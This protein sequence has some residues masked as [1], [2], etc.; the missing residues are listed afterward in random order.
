MQRKLFL[1][2]FVAAFVPVLVFASGKISGKVTDAGTGE[3]LVGANVVV[4]GTQMGAATNVSGEYVILNVPTGTYTIRSTYVGY[5][6]ITITNLMVNNDLT[7]EAN[8]QLP[9]EGVTVG[10]VEI[11]A[12]RPLVNKNATNAVRIIDADFFT[13]VP[14]RGINAAIQT[15]P[16]VVY[17]GGNIYIRGGRADEVGYQLEGVG[18]NDIVNGGRA[19]NITAEAVEQIQVQAGGF[20]AEY[21]GANAGLVQ[22]QLRTG[23]PDKWKAS[24]LGETDRYMGLNKPSKLGGYSYGYGDLTATAGGPIVSNKFRFFGSLQGTYYGDQSVRNQAGGTRAPYDFSGANAIVAD[25]AITFGHSS[26]LPDTLNLVLPGGNA[27]GGYERTLIGS[28]TL[29]IDLS[30][31]QVRLAGSYAYDRNK[32]QTTLANLLN[33]G[34]LGLNT[35]RD[36]FGNVK[37]SHVISPTMF[38]EANFDYYNQTFQTE[39]PDFGSNV[40]AYGDSAANAALGYHLLANSLNY[41]A[42]SLWGGAFGVNQPGTQIAGFEKRSQTSIGGRV[43]F[44]MQLKQHEVKVG[45]SY[46]R[47]TIRE[48]NPSSELSWYRLQKEATSADQLELELM[49]IGGTGSNTYGYDVFG[50]QINGDVIK[51]GAFYYMGPRHPG[52]GAAYIQDKIELSDIILN[53]GLR[54]DYINPDS[55]DVK[56]PS[57]LTFTGQDLIVSDNIIATGKTNQISPRIGLSFPVTDRTVFHAQFGKFIQQTKLSDSYLGASSMAGIIKGGF[58]VTGTWGWGLKPTRTTQY[59][60]GFSQQVSDFASFDINAFFKDIQDQIDWANIAPAPGTGGQNYAALVNRDFSTSQGVEFK[61]TMRRTNRISASLGYTFSSVTTTGSNTASAAGLWSAGSVVALPHYTFPADWN[62]THRG[63]VLFDYRFA[64]NDGGPVLEQLGLDVLLTFNSGHNFT[65]LI[66]QQRI[67]GNAQPTDPRF[68]IPVEPIGS[69]TS[70]WFF[71]LDARLD[72]TFSVG[73]LDLNVYVYV[74]NLLGTDNPVGAFFRTGDPSDDGWFSTAGGRADAVSNGQ[75]YVDFY[76]AVAL[77][78]NS[79]NYGP[80]RQIRFGLKL[81]Y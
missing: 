16:G 15:A 20:T 3:P 24:L 13:N 58:F 31:V 38:Y 42:Y 63:T 30:P 8:F 34:R 18:V 23:S 22:T 68:R 6:T 50:N 81:D 19:V 67:S 53:I 78:E 46:Q 29:L 14:A 17:Q 48:Y 26:A 2:L 74:I 21:G 44:T 72:K 69:S 54:Y 40:F 7:T 39:D 55:K 11:V 49:K 70:P 75:Q 5:Q 76:R 32:N 41:G 25:P 45:G 64:K 71:Q 51:N 35:T 52:F 80:P 36:G 59:E 28:G 66:A 79:G 57:S 43:D 47:Y 73:P 10:T 1:A 60:A 33:Q 4:V 37:I 61:F 62:Q 9:S 65:R 12:E 56:D 27:L 77:G